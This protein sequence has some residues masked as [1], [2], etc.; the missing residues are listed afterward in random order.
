MNIGLEY[1]KP[2]FKEAIRFEQNKS[3]ATELQALWSES[4]TIY[5]ELHFMGFKNRW[6]L[7]Q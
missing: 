2:F 4:D 6:I 1:L 7:F 5:L 3:E